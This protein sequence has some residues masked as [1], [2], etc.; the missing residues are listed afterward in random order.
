[1]IRS[2]D[3]ATHYTWGNG[4]DG[5]VHLDSRNL[6]VIEE[7]MPPGATEQRHFHSHAHQVFLVTSGLLTLERDAEIFELAVGQS[8]DVP[9]LVSHTAMNCSQAD[10]V[11]M[12]ISS[13]S[14]RGD[15]TDR[16]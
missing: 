11:F 2:R 16:E 12:V 1:M 4:C 3:N 5:W 10:A 15:R 9:P 8:L 13:P 14:T 6:L 7:R